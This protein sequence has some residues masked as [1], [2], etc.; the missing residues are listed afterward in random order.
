MRLV[1]M[2]LQ[3]ASSHGLGGSSLQGKEGQAARSSRPGR[4]KRFAPA[5]EF[6]K[7]LDKECRRREK[8]TKE[9]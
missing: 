4:V 8:A 1:R 7:R 6:L 2:E 9:E 5:R 3:I